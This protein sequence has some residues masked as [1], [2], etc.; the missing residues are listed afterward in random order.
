MNSIQIGLVGLPNVGK[1]TL[2]N[3]L[4]KSSVPAENYP[5]CTIDPHAAITTVPDER[6]EKLKKIYGSAKT[7][8]NTV[9]FVDIA[10]L[11]KG[12]ATGQGLGNQF[13]SHIREVNLIAHVI[14]CFD[15]GNIIHAEG[16][17]DPIRDYETIVAE[18]MLK[19]IDSVEK[20]I[21]KLDQLIKAAKNKPLELKELEA[22]KALLPQLLVALNGLDAAKVHAL[23][24]QSGIKTLFLLSAKNSI[25]IANI[26]EAELD[27]SYIQ[28]HHYQAVIKKFGDANVIPICAKLE[29][30]L[31]RLDDHEAQELMQEFGLRERGLNNIIRSSFGHLGMITFFTCGPKEI[32]AWAIKK[33]LTVRQASGEIHSDLERGF[34]CAEVF[35]CNDLFTLG[36]EAKIKE[37]GKMRI[38]GQDYIVKDGDIINVRFNV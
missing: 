29:Y 31:S 34:I 15:D 33:G 22:E 24:E 19:D 28:N 26:S 18:L 3:A 13:L 20:R 10:G 27:G 17:V 30:E 38:E 16:A 11:V 23:I 35:N 5:F 4:T 9:T 7:I 1:S 36:S 32:H 14:R 2:F 8:P 6:I 21:S 37:Q 25:I 12:A